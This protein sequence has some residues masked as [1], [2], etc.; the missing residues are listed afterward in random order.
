MSFDDLL[1]HYRN[2]DMS[3]RDYL[4]G[5]VLPAILVFFILV[6][7]PEYIFPDILLQ[8]FLSIITRWILPAVILTL[9]LTFP[10]LSRKLKE[11]E[12][13]SRLHIFTTYFWALSTSSVS[14]LE[15]LKRLS[16]EEEL[17]ELGDELK[18]IY[19]RMEFW[20][21]PL[22]EAAR[23]VAETTPSEKLSDFLTRLA[24]SQEAGERLEVFLEKEHSVVMKDYETE[25]ESSLEKLDM[26]K[27]VFVALMTSA[28]FLMVFLSILPIFT[29]GSPMV[30][31]AEGL[32]VFVLM[33]IT[34]LISIKII[35]PED[36]I[37][38]SLETKSPIQGKLKRLLPLT[39]IAS[40]LIFIFTYNY[41]QFE[42]FWDIAI[43]ALP[44]LVPG[45]LILLAERKL[46][47]CDNNYDAFMR[48][49][50]GSRAASAGGEEAALAKLRR[51][52]FGPLTEHIDRLYKRI[53]TRIDD[54]RA[55]EYFASDTGSNLIANFT[56]TYTGSM[57][58]GGDI[59][60]VSDII[61]DTFVRLL[62]L[63]KDRYQKAS[64]LVGVLY[65]LEL[66]AALTLTLTLNIALMMDESLGMITQTSQFS[67][68]LHQ[69]GYG[70]GIINLFILLA[71]I[72]HAVF[73]SLSLTYSSGSHKLSSLYHIVPMIWLGAVTA[74]GAQLIMRGMI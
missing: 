49:V 17:G 41:F 29:G 2:M 64:D 34:M 39:V 37:W 27:E 56:K 44:F 65:G 8:D 16:K 24:H 18:K 51:Y 46:K 7:F 61:S 55:W 72:S 1:D 14:E 5:G 3:V 19:N 71:I 12:I 22:P 6:L 9:A 48:A 59:R 31:L 45:I 58:I 70:A 63:R 52:D 4:L 73:S 43:S 33:E 28:L 60:K 50:A 67:G 13:D 23:S 10:I 36:D 35:M 15:M 25:Y 21:I 32:V 42:I 53:L 47:R 20:D 38:H 62:S 26:V 66:G 40:V 69:V 68:I 54:E 11:E 57:E 30:L 74:I